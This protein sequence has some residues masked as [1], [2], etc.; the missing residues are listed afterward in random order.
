MKISSLLLSITASASAEILFAGV[1]E[2]SGEFGLYSDD[3]TPG[4]GLPG[5]FGTD[6][7][8]IDEGAVDIFIDE[9]KVLSCA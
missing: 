4:T 1:A 5:E 7:A 6:Y 9:H 8:F 2:S 3:G